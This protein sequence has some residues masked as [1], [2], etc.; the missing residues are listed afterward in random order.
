VANEAITIE[1]ATS[2]LAASLDVP[3]NT[4]APEVIRLMIEA[5]LCR[6]GKLVRLVEP[7]GKPVCTNEPQP[8]LVKLLQ[9]SRSWW[10]EMQEDQL[11]ATQMARRH[12]VDK[13][14]ISR[15]TR[16]S[17]LAPAITEQMLAGEQPPDLD[18]RTL[19]GLHSL[20]LGWEEQ[21][22]RLLSR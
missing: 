14:Y 12:N 9:L 5:R 15:V 21:E 16:L 4:D 20:P 22:R 13:S 6:T 7:G 1:V 17:F 3:K 10:R 19:L 2:D 8:H 11:N 18:A